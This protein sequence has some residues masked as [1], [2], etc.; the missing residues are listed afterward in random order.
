MCQKDFFMGKE[1]YKPFLSA[2][3]FLGTL[4]GAV[5]LPGVHAA[6]M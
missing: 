5:A 6:G 1:S 3:M 4:H 2:Y